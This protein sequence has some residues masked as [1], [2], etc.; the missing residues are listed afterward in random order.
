[1]ERFT[2]KN[3]HGLKLV[4]QADT[5]AN[6]QNLVFVA[7]GQG[8]FIEQRHIQAFADAFL[9]NNF[10]IVRFDATHSH[11][12]SEGDIKDVTFTG[13][14]ED[15]EDVISWARTQD[16]FK[17]PFAL[18][19]H[20]MGGL[21]A[22]YY[23][24]QHPNKTLCVA[25]LS[26]CINYEFFAQAHGAEYMREW[27]RRGYLKKESRSKPGTYFEIGWQVAEDLKKY[28]LL[29]NASKLTMPV[30]LMAGSE[31]TQTPYG[32][33]KKL[34][35]EIPNEKKKLVRI[36]DVEHSFRNSDGSYSDEKLTEVKDAISDW[37]KEYK[38]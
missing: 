35:D 3:R 33:Q 31:D 37:L 4:I 9:E 18:I 14:I 17:Q 29:K 32:Q 6:P 28:D 22:G 7:H 25:P 38:V 24:E 1:M 30:L 8:G 34:F 5:P 19:G 12:E 21:S 20:S 2:T 27:Q 15:L 13:Y 36:E 26:A 11:G 10:R 23:A 16:W